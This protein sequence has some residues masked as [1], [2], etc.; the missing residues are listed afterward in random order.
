VNGQKGR[1]LYS[2][3]AGPN[4]ENLTIRVSEDEGETWPVSRLL[5]A[6]SAAYSDLVVLPDGQIGC[7]YERDGYRAIRFARFTLDWLLAGEH[8]P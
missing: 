1:I 4:R 7:L 5:H 8:A 6:Q 2:G 3:P